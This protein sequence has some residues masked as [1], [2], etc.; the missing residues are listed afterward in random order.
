MSRYQRVTCSD[1]NNEPLVVCDGCGKRMCLMH[2]V[3]T[4]P[5]PDG[6]DTVDYCIRCLDLTNAP[7]PITPKPLG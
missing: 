6:T 1:C 3:A 7:G 4:W 5:T 2:R